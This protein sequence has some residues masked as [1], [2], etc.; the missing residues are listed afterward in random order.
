MGEE[1]R[2]YLRLALINSVN[3]ICEGC[4]LGIDLDRAGFSIAV[5]A[6]TLMANCEQTSQVVWN[7]NNRQT[8]SQLGIS[9]EDMWKFT[10]INYNAGGGCL[11]TA[12]ELASEE[13]EEVPLTFDGISPFLEPA[14]QGAIEYVNQISGQ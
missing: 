14:C 9:Y 7:Y 6:R 13:E 2:A 12:F 10:L 1:N 11:A 5:F 4:P 3:S 8:P